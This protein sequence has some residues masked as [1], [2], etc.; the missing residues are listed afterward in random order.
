VRGRDPLEPG[1]DRAIAADVDAVVVEG[2]FC[3]VEV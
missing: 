2:R 3:Q 1:P